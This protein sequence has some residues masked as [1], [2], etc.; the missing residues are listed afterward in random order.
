VRSVSSAPAVRRPGRPLAPRPLA[1]RP[2]APRPLA[3]RP[4]APRPRRPPGSNR[5]GLLSVAV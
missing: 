1:P 2:L 5:S 4:L 3:P